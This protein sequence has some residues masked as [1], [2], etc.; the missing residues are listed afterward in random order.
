MLEREASLSV[1]LG[2]SVLLWPPFGGYFCVKID[3]L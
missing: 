1:P 3:M 2:N